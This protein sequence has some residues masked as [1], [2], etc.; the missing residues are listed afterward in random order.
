[1]EVGADTDAIAIVC[2]RK[3]S[4]HAS[5]RVCASVVAVVVGW[6]DLMGRGNLTGE[7]LLYDVCC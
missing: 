3:E 4:L 1:M 2:K 7:K 6:T 5:A